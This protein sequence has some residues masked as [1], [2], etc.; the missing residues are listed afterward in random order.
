MHEPTSVRGTRTAVIM[1]GCATALFHLL[2]AIWF[3]TASP[4]RAAKTD[5]RLSGEAYLRQLPTWDS[6]HEAD[7][8]FYNRGAI[9]VMRAGVPRTRSGMFLEHAPLYAYFVAGCYEIG[10]VRLLSLVV[11]QALLSGFTA[12]LLALVAA[13]LAPSAPSLAALFAGGFVLV[14]LNLAGYVGTASP[15]TLLVFLFALALWGLVCQR[16]RWQQVVFVGALVAAVYAQAAFFIIA[17]GIGGWLL[18]CFWRTRQYAWLAGAVVL[19]AFAL[20][21][22]AIGLLINR[23]LETHSKEAPTAVLWEA[24]NPYYESMTP[25]SLWERRP[26]NYWSKWKLTPEEERRFQS[27][28]ER[29]GGNG[30]KAAL[31]W[32]RENPRDY[33]ELC[34]VRLGAV[35][36]PV[37]GQMSPLLKKVAL[38][39]WLAVFPAGFVGLWRLRRTPFVTLAACVILAEVSF[40]VLVI[41]GWQPRYRLPIDLILFVA[42]AGVYAP[43]VGR[44]VERIRNRSAPSASA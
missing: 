20:L 11:G 34:V 24:N 27:Y 12:F 13:R 25:F 33:L 28:L 37:T 5:L 16:G 31:L 1:V 29:G 15:T 26:G 43:W 39:M 36:G 21:K 41:A 4:T 2:F 3:W 23:D 38:V 6:E 32:I 42:A 18:L 30:T 14:S 17:L 22:P 35:L 9:E 44:F 10:G 7:A 19:A 8:A 40:E